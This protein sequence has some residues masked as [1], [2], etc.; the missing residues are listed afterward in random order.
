MLLWPKKE[1]EGAKHSLDYGYISFLYQDELHAALTNAADSI[2]VTV[3]EGE[4][5]LKRAVTVRLR[6]A[7]DNEI[8]DKWYALSDLLAH[9]SLK[10]TRRKNGKDSLESSV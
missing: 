3:A 2:G 6:G 4:A 7:D 8:M 10:K 5:Y 9:L 1:H